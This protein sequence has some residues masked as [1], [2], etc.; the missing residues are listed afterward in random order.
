MLFIEFK[1]FKTLE[2][3]LYAFSINHIPKNAI[4]K[5]LSNVT[6]L[7]HCVENIQNKDRKL[8]GIPWWSSG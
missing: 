1:E 3:L 7:E 5:F 2:V 4:S 8:G 6:V